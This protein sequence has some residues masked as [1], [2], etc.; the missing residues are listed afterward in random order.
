MS[1]ADLSLIPES[2]PA[3]TVRGDRVK[4]MK[5]GFAITDSDRRLIRDNAYFI[6]EALFSCMTEA[7]VECSVAFARFLNRFGLNSENYWLFLRLIIAN[8]SWVIDELLHERE[9]RLLFSTIRPERDLVEAAFQA[10]YSRHPEELYP[11]ALVALLGIVENAYFDPDDGYKVRKL[12][13]MDINALGKFLLKGEPQEHPQNRLVLEI[14]DRM[15]HLNEYF[16]EPEKS[17]LSKHAFNVR[18]AYFDSTRDLVD[19]IPH[20]LLVHVPDFGKVAPEEDYADLVTRRRERKRDAAGRFVREAAAPAEGALPAEPAP[21]A[22][23]PPAAPE[24]GRGGRTA[25]PAPRKK[26]KPKA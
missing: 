11:K 1:R 20:P 18:Y 21:V 23:A 6:R 15:T 4:D 3:D 7:Q 9:P 25:A 2:P 16:Q 12:S 26:R 22:V 24:P 14:L 19:A 8:N 13:I 10:L 5:Q 17:V